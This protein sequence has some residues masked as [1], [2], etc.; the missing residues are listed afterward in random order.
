VV[1]DSTAAKEWQECLAKADFA[2]ACARRFDLIETMR[3]DPVEGILLLDRHLARLAASAAA[4]GF[5]LDRH[6]VRNELQAA[7]FRLTAPSRVRLMLARSGRIA[8]E[9]QALPARP[10]MPA[11][12]AI[13]PRPVSASDFRLVHK[14]SDRSFYDQARIASGR[15][16]VVF[17][18]DDG[19]LTEGSFT[20]VFVER[21][22]VL[23][24]PPLA[25]GLLPGVL[26]EQLIEQGRAVEA[27]LTEYDL[28][29]GFLVGNALRGLIPARLVAAQHGQRL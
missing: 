18:D 21:D 7:T 16:E 3:F 29:R 24:T 14:T 8:I 28:A 13:A 11:E 20:N 26:R 27:E 10:V 23:A 12:V 19:F 22:G 17:V 1:A 5:A 6:A 4:L 2:A 25:R 15:F 9:T